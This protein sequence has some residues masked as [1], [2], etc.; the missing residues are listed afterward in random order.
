MAFYAFWSEHVAFQTPLDLR[1]RGE[2]MTL[3]LE[4]RYLFGT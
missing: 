2:L 3:H 1:T 4:G